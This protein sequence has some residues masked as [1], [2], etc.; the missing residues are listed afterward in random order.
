MCRNFGPWLETVELDD[1]IEALERKVLVTPHGELPQQITINACW[2][3]EGLEVLAWALGR[4]ELPALDETSD[5]MQRIKYAGVL[6]KP[7]RVA[8]IFDEAE[9]R[10]AEQIEAQA[11]Q[12]LA[13]HWR[14]RSFSLKPE[15]MNFRE[16]AASVDWATF[17]LEGLPMIDND[18]AIG[19]RPI[20]D[21]DKALFSRA[22]S[23][24]QERHIATNWLI[25]WDAIYSE[26]T[27]DT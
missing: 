6:A 14:L 16:Y 5:A 26:V 25:G 23:L 10:E 13:L 18:L 19:G 3:M 22:M 7:E 11:S 21:C 17:N 15:A 4:S 1:E 2:R 12:Q 8:I 20:V 24:A 9:L 27:A